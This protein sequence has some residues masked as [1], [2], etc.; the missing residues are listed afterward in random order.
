MSAINNGQINVMLDLETL[1]VKPGARILS[2]GA[3]LFGLSDPRAIRYEFE[4]TIS[5]V[6]Q[7][8]MDTPDPETL[9]WWSKKDEEVKA[10]ACGGTSDLTAVLTDFN[11]WLKLM[12]EGDAG[13][14]INIWG[15]GATFD[16]PIIAE[17]MR[18]YLV[19]PVWNYKGAMCYR[20]LEE[21]GKKLGLVLPPLPEGQKHIAINDARHQAFCADLILSAMRGER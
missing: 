19:T 15:K 5:L 1:G 7:E 12:A 9:D 8:R 21:L 20:T 14:K 16:E 6:G 17:A 2:I 10:I 11:A 13:V 4:R 18:R 3:V